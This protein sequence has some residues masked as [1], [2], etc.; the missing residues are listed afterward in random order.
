MVLFVGG[1][2]IGG[3]MV[4]RA[5]DEARKGGVVVGGEV[6]VVGGEVG[7]VVGGE[8]IGGGYHVLESIQKYI[9]PS[10][11]KFDKK[12]NMVKPTFDFVIY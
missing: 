3:G 1:E 7:V 5:C 4:A 11:C 10:L 8:T 6:V 12:K 9:W 2:A